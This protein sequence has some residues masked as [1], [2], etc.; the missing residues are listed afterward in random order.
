MINLNERRKERKSGGK[1]EGKKGKGKQR[2]ERGEE[3]QQGTKE[4]ERKGKIEGQKEC[5]NTI[6]LQIN[7]LIKMLSYTCMK[8][9]GRNR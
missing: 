8:D 7:Q 3:K 6:L 2:K 5:W 9:I 1:I 4:K